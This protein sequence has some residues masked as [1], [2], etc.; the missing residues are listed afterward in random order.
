MSAGR[1]RRVPLFVSGA[2]ALVAALAVGPSEGR[3][4]CGDYVT[5]LT[6][7]SHRA[8]PP[9]PT[10]RGCSPAPTQAAPV[11]APKMVERPTPDGVVTADPVSP[12]AVHDTRA[13]HRT[14]APSAA[15]PADIFHPPR[16]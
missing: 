10:C 1:H 2:L 14:A 11:P 3:A 13:T 12:P 6:A 5:V 4:A 8:P 16:A 7:D 15:H 9:N